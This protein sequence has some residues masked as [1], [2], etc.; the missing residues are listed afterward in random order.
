M[1]EADAPSVP[2]PSRTAAHRAAWEAGD[3]ARV[4]SAQTIVG[5]LLCEAVELHAR[6]RILDVATGSGNTA[7]AA[8]RRRANVF[9]I[10]FVPELLAR[11]RERAAAERLEAAF[12]EGL[13]EEL[14]FPDSA[15]DG[16][17]SAFGVM[18][19]PDPIRAAAELVRVCRPG[20]RL[21]LASWTPEGFS[22]RVFHLTARH[23]PTAHGLG[24]STE[25][26]T[27]AGMQ[28]LFSGHGLTPSFV[29]RNAVLTADSPDK[30]VTF[31]RRYFGPTV[32]AFASLDPE[33]Q[34]RLEEA[35]LREVHRTN[36]ARDGTTYLRS[37]YLEAV[38]R[39][40]GGSAVGPEGPRTATG[41]RGTD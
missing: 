12:L 13:A 19:A 40:P 3:L 30:Y 5:E 36:L 15:F 4:A 20:G 26:G 10:D 7:L 37:E 9:G 6:E 32:V 25:W 11:A 28:R 27:E 29:R 34:R 2:V 31:F 41:A 14:P 33:G 16:V 17:L 23:A 18:F 24:A 1:R 8:A 21:G 38:L 35:L 39:K 22:G